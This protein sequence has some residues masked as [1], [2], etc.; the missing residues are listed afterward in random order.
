MGL[1][2]KA[3]VGEGLGRQDTRREMLLYIPLYSFN[4]NFISHWSMCVKGGPRGPSPSPVGGGDSEKFRLAGFW[5][6]E[7]GSIVG[8]GL[9]PLLGRPW[10]L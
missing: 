4:I 6:Q 3:P 10:S 5:P 8:L 7:G 2:A 1:A 9:G